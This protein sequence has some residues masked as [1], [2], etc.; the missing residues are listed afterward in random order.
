MI[1][2]LKKS[3]AIYGIILLIALCI[4]AVSANMPF[5]WDTVLTA[6]MASFFY[7][8]GLNAFIV[9]AELDNGNIP[10]YGLYLSLAWKIFGRSLMVSHWSFFPFILI[11]F[12][13]VLRLSSRYI[14]EP[15]RQMMIVLILLVN[16][17]II[18]QMLLMAYDIILAAFFLWA[19]NAMLAGKNL[20]YAVSL[21]LIALVTVRGWIFFPALFIMQ[22]LLVPNTSWKNR[23]IN[24][25]PFIPVTVLM[26]VW[27]IYHKN[28]TGWLIFSPLMIETDRHLLDFSMIYR[29]WIYIVWKNLDMGNIILWFMLLFLMIRKIKNAEKVKLKYFFSANKEGLPD[30]A[31]RTSAP[32]QVTKEILL[33]TFIPAL[34]LSASMSLMSNPIGHRYF[35]VPFT[36]ITVFAVVLIYGMQKKIFRT[37]SFFIIIITLISGNFWMYPQRY[38]NG[39]DCSLKVLPYF[40]LDREM[41]DFIS[42]NHI[43]P[44]SVGTDFPLFESPLFTRL[45]SNGSGYC[46]MEPFTLSHFSF[47]LHS[48]VSN[49]FHPDSL[50]KIRI[51]WPVSYK[52]SRN[53][54][55]MTL[56]KNPE[57][58]SSLLTE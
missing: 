2:G 23:F 9:P 8:E 19:L 6:R 46:D 39:W 11:Y 10:S 7:F 15:R 43:D 42:D 50:E 31:G 29:Q 48:N 55:N 58:Y 28:Q 18:T 34:L 20:Q 12:Y 26:I 51:N 35:V 45:D 4:S 22:S 38:G 44:K 3:M 53:M 52:L 1:T 36:I 17:V 57:N 14:A 41:R 32:L 56:Y 16:P 40:K 5:F 37:I 54:V 27:L 21:V 24:V 13:Q 30:N 25:W 33:I 47:I 49:K